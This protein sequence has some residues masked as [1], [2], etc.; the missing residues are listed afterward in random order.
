[1]LKKKKEKIKMS[2]KMK[3]TIHRRNKKVGNQ[4]S[5]GVTSQVLN[6][7]RTGKKFL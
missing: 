5:V 4:I 2:K 7:R 1:M 3:R 6:R